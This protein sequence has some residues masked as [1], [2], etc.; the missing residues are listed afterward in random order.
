MKSVKKKIMVYS[1]L[2]LMQA[3]L[4]TGVASAAPQY[5]AETSN[6][7]SVL[8][9]LM[10]YCENIFSVKNG[11]DLQTDYEQVLPEKSRD[12]NNFYQQFQKKCN[13]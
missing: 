8:A 2:G 13:K 10:Q 12:S 5:A 1:M 11:S 3:G 6:P 4:F 9:Y 7:S